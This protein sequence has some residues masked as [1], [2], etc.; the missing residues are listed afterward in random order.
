MF[1]LL[2]IILLVCAGTTLVSTCHS[3]SNIAWQH[4]EQYVNLSIQIVNCDYCVF[5]NYGTEH[6]ISIFLCVFQ[7]YTLCMSLLSMLY[8]NIISV[9]SSVKT[10]IATGIQSL[11]SVSS[12]YIS[13]LCTVIYVT[14]I[15]L[16]VGA[17]LAYLPIV[18]AMYYYYN[19]A[20]ITL[21]DF[22]FPLVRYIAYNRLI[23]YLNFAFVYYLLFNCVWLKSTLFCQTVI[24]YVACI[25]HYCSVDF[26]LLVL[27]PVCLCTSITHTFGSNYPTVLIQSYA[28]SYVV[29][30]WVSVY[31]YPVKLRRNA[32]LLFSIYYVSSLRFHINNIEYFLATFPLL[33][34]LA[35]DVHQ[36]PG[37]DSDFKAVSMCH[38]NIRSLS[39]DKL[40][41][42]RSDL[43]QE[44]DIIALSETFLSDNQSDDNFVIHDYHKIIRRDR[45][46]GPGGGVALFVSKYFLISRRYDLEV[47][48]LE[49]LWCEI[50]INNNKFLV[51]VVYRPPN[52][53]VSF[54]DDFQISYDMARASG[55]NNIF[56]LGDLNADANTPQGIKLQ[57]FCTSNLVSM[58][59]NEPTR[60]TDTSSSC[61]DQI[62]SNKPCFVL[63][64][65]VLPPILN[66]DHCVVSA[67]LS[68]K[69]KQ[70]LSY[71]R[72]IWEYAK[73]DFDLFRNSL[74]NFNWDT[75]FLSDDV[76]TCCKAW[77]D[78]F[79]EVARR[80]IPSKTII[81]RPNDLPWYDGTLR[82]L[83]R[84]VVRAHKKAKKHDRPEDWANFRNLRNDYQ[85]HLQSAEEQYN[86][87]LSASLCNPGTK[88]K[89]WWR[90]VK[91]FLNRNH[92]SNIPPLLHNDEYISD[93]FSKAEVFNSFFLSQCNVDSSSST[94]PPL[95]LQPATRTLSSVHILENEVMEILNNIDVSKATG[96]DEISPR[97]LK[98]AAP[99]ICSSLT[100]LCNLSLNHN[101]FPSP[102]KCA[103]VIPLHKKDAESLCNNYRPIS[104]LSCVSKVMER[105]VF[106]HVFNFFR[107]NLVLSS[108]QS[109]FIPGDSTVNQLLSLYHELCLAVDLRKD[110]RVVFLDVSK[111]FDKVWHSALLHKL[112]K[113]GISG[114]LLAW[115][116]S[117][118]SD[119]KQRVLIK[120]Q[121][122]NWGNINA[123]V[124][125]G[126]VLGPL[127]F[128]IFINDIVDVVNSNIKL[129]AD[130]TS[131]YLTVDDPQTA[132][133][134]L[135][136]DLS[137]L[138]DWSK[139]WLISF[140][141][142]KTNSMTVS[143]KAHQLPHPPLFFQNHQLEDV[144]YHR[145]LGITLRSNLTWSQHI[146]QIVQKANKLI[147]ILKCLQFRLDRNSLE[148]IY[149]SFIRPLLEYGSPIWDGCTQADADRLESIQIAAARVITGAMK[150]TSVSKLYEEIGWETLAE[151][152]KKAKLIIMYKIINNLTPT[153][154][155][156]LLPETPPLAMNHNTRHRPDIYPFRARTSLFEKSFF[157]STVR[158]WNQLPHEIR[159]A[160]SLSQFKSKLKFTPKQPIQYL[161]LLYFGKRHTAIKHTRLRLGCSRLNSHLFKIGVVDSPLCSCGTGVEDTLHYLFTCP[162][163]RNLRVDLSNKIIPIAPFTSQTVLYGN[164]TCSLD[165][166]YLIFSAVHEYIEKTERL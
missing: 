96:P 78:S 147:N 28:L 40:S 12:L 48:N 116:H 69:Y 43:S 1:L 145:H 139:Q 131:L 149:I 110:V 124:P 34:L 7:Y 137:S 3:V 94:L 67:K 155:R 44:F 5:Q 51:G 53:P 154:L 62:L 63:E 84:G 8:R 103:N 30:A 105:I 27:M 159:N 54:W 132:A 165:D 79:L 95:N 121:S 11:I 39:Q 4:F 90:T 38:A 136:T 10:N 141:A 113:N 118:L 160:V 25:F 153:Y 57:Q 123:G 91:Y 126:S 93:N 17:F 61:L 26:M 64:T 161:E 49:L 42:I 101:S 108:H 158:L 50:R 148:T 2:L 112:E 127:L 45:S 109:G 33:I 18:V 47:N 163:Y 71:E 114:N 83:K 143:R 166:N 46:S 66:C 13:R 120:G 72:F 99:S 32:T 106:K 86:L 85:E 162:L 6:A 104:L 58:H 140:N 130:D 35:G 122:S 81:I 97:L 77:T 98:E 129:F 82:Y 73:A 102:W 119:R 100:R 56:V 80:C 74:A 88:N 87:K 59:I 37:P 151:R 142:L 41:F 36:N 65:E 138:D 135:N 125:Q 68:F 92:C 60:I 115:F 29:M 22:G 150:G 76:N 89:T 134:T 156:D 133:G 52:S 9:F 152:R 15:C 31:H 20:Q 107:D 111:A 75:C 21:N 157:P 117:Y 144:S 146:N 16:C 164:K 19:S 70:E 55:I 23:T 128:L 14:F 24:H